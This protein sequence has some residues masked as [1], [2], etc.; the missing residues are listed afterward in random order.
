MAKI[1]FYIALTRLNK[2]IG[3]YLLLWPTLSALVIAAEGN[4]SLKH[5]LIFTFGV[6]VMRSA[7]CIINDF[8]DR[9]FDGFV[10]RTKQRPLANGSLTTTEALTFCIVLLICATLLV[11]LTN[12]TTIYLASGALLVAAIY[13]F[14]KRVTYY[15]QLVLG[16]AFSWGILMSFTAEQ[17]QLPAKAWW[18][19]AANL[20]WTV[21]YDTYYALSDIKDD[22]QIGIKSTAIIF[23]KQARD[24]C[25]ILQIASLSCWI[26]AGIQFNLGW[27]FYASLIIC[28]LI[29]IAGYIK[30]TDY[31]PHKCFKVFLSN[32][33]AGFIIFMSLIAD[34]HIK[35]II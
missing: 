14:M 19:F 26:I 9:D 20:L 31:E 7:G 32:H 16:I 3:I 33:W 28:L 21:A 24:I 11:I 13:P 29:F 35:P 15:P 10:A 30:T 17:S 34:Y 1:K 27:Y 22:L 23:G 2:P 6:I 18:L 8:A 4:P 5:W 12:I 25:L